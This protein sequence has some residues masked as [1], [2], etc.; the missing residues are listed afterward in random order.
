MVPSVARRESVLNDQ[1]RNQMLQLAGGREKLGLVA[2]VIQKPG[3]SQ[4]F[5]FRL[6]GGGA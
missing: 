5:V 1:Q 3:V 2:S 6:G 4:V